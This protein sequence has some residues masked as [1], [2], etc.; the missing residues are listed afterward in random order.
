[1]GDAPYQLF[2]TVQGNEIG[3]YEE[4]LKVPEGW[5]RE[6]ERQRS[7]NELCLKVAG[8]FSV[9]V[10]LAALGVFIRGIRKDEVRWETA[11]PWGWVAFFAL[12]AVASQLNDIPDLIFDYRTTSRGP[13]LSP[14]RSPGRFSVLLQVLGFWLLLVVADCIYRERPAWEIFLSAC[15]GPRRLARSADRPRAR[16]RHRL[17]RLLARLHLRVLFGGPA[18]RGLVFPSK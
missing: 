17:R 5:T 6:Y 18:H 9:A 14:V 3:L 2:V 10:L 13:P 12:V 8:F 7:V 15:P 4:R 16:G 11:V 1:M